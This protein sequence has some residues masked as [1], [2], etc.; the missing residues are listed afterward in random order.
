M[1]QPPPLRRPHNAIELRILFYGIVYIR[2][3]RDTFFQFILVQVYQLI[4]T[5]R[6]NIYFWCFISG[7]PF[8]FT[9][10]GH[11]GKIFYNGWLFPGMILRDFCTVLGIRVLKILTL[12]LGL[13]P[14][15]RG[16]F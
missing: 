10:T 8:F 3:K 12:F 5:S 14:S 9:S 15:C 6:C 13:C 2:K 16:M 11:P 7:L 4:L 1:P